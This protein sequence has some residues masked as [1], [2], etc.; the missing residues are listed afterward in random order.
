MKTLITPLEVI[1]NA[2][3]DH[4]FDPNLVCSHIPNVEYRYLQS[5]KGCFGLLFYKD[6]LS[7]LVDFVNYDSTVTYAIN[8]VVIYDSKFYK[9]LANG[10]Q[11]FAP[12]DATKWLK[13][14]KFTSVDYQELWDEYL[15][16]Y[17]AVATQHAST[18]TNSYRSTSK[19]VMRNESDNSKPAE[20]SGVKA[21]KD[22][23]MANV[24]LLQE[25]METY[26]KDNKDKFPLYKGNSDCNSCST[27]K[28]NT[29]L[30]LYLKKNRVVE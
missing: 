6:L 15:C 8:T 1:K 29:S 25:R 24:M 13:V 16:K 2:Y 20:Y 9:C 19:G 28:R 7:K 12:T 21:L 30:G 23:L 3:F 11:G 5:D 17:L 14:S 18:F 26:L 10:T 27:P 4:N 22:E